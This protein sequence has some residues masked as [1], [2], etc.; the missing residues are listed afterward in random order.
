MGIN[1]HSLEVVR[2]VDVD[3][4]T[5]QIRLY[6]PHCQQAA[7]RIPLLITHGGPGGSSVGLYDALNPLA[8]QRPTIFTT[9]WAPLHH[10]RIWFR[11]R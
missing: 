1:G 11:S 4:G 10:R 8:D 3:G 9:S 6:R 2:D 7:D 5:V